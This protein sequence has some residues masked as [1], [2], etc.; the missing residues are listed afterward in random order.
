[1][2]LVDRHWDTINGFLDENM[3]RRGP[4]QDL[5]IAL[6]AFLEVAIVASAELPG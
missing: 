1:M 6:D 5:A 3:A 2:T 4:R